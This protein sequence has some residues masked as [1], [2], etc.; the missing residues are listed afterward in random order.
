[1][2]T[3]TDIKADIQQLN[4]GS[5]LISLYRIDATSKGG[6]VYYFT[7]GTDSGSK[8]TFNSIEYN[9]APIEI[10]GLEQSK[11]GKMVRPTVR[12]T[13]INYL[14]LA[15]VITY[16]GLVGCKLYRI[17]TFEKYLDGHSHADPNAHFP[18][19]IY[20]V[21]RRI[22]QNKNY[23]E[24][25]LRSPLDLENLLLPKGQ[26]LPMCTHKYSTTE[27]WATCPYDGSNG[28]FKSDGEET[29]D[30]D[31]DE[32]GKTLSDCRLRFNIDESLPFKG[33]P[34]IGNFGK[35]WR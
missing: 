24:W 5:A 23:I 19:E 12:I 25:E 28:Y 15:E 22:S 6:S 34:G 20:I 18:A 27:S 35:P 31:E 26:C 33:F 21:N 9:P 11:D 29:L 8:V 1:M 13:N 16:N 4:P 14:L 32:C 2:T 7:T 30:V 10:D 17:R 3:N